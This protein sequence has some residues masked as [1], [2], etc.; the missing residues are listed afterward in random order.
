MLN[1]E[2]I[3]LAAVIAICSTILLASCIY[4]YSITPQKTAFFQ[5][6]LTSPD[7]AILPAELNVTSGQNNDLSITVQNS[8]GNTQL[9]TLNVE[10]LVLNS[11]FNSL[12]SMALSNYT[13]YIS[14][15]GIWAK[16]FTYQINNNLN[17]NQT[18]QILF[19]NDQ[20]QVSQNQYNQNLLFQFRFD[21]WAFNTSNNTYV[22]TNTWV[23][24]PF[25]TVAT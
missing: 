21:L 25:L 3:R 6:S 13:F 9:C 2:E 20:V 16:N 22:F 14:S 18:L 8:M 10:L 7:G 4:I 24:S 5:L 15:N 23:S 17:N 12:N 11:S 19:N 1:K